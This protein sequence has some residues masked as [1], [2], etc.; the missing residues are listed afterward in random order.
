MGEGE[1]T[2]EVTSSAA[3]E[4]STGL[5]DQGNA[6]RVEERDQLL[7]ERAEQLKQHLAAQERAE[8][9][10][11]RAAS[12]AHHEQQQRIQEEKRQ[13]ELEET[14]RRLAK[15]SVLKP[16][17]VSTISKQPEVPR[18]QPSSFKFPGSLKPS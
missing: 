6:A 16:P 7:N 8:Q 13:Q 5:S 4:L 9:E 2:A 10:E 15:V 18:P 17:P 11:R 1:G 14:R 3:A 12:T